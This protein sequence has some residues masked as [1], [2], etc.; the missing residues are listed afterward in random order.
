[1]KFSTIFL[2]LFFFTQ[3][4]TSQSDPTETM[5]RTY[6]DSTD[7][8]VKYC[9]IIPSGKFLSKYIDIQIDYGQEQAIFKNSYIRDE[10]GN[11][12]T[13]NSIVHALNYMDSLGW[14]LVKTYSEQETENNFRSYY[15]FKSEGDATLPI[16]QETR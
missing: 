4:A 1:M 16:N 13:F 14:E 9:L 7:I 10:D 6:Q 15:L 3:V 8:P 12:R 5:D 11:K 2:L